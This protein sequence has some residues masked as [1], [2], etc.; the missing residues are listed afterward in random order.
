MRGSSDQKLTI[1]FYKGST[2]VD[3][4]VLYPGNSGKFT[5]TYGTTYGKAN[6][7]TYYVKVTK[8]AKLSGKYRIKYVI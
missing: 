5:L 7:G 3:S 4:T 2:K 1:T 8:T 6:A